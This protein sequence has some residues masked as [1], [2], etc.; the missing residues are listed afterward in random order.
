MELG[1]VLGVELT[2][3][4]S[5]VLPWEDW[6]ISLGWRKVSDD[7]ISAVM[8][9]GWPA[10][11]AAMFFRQRATVSRWARA[12]DLVLLPTANAALGGPF[13]PAEHLLSRPIVVALVRSVSHFGARY[14]VQGCQ[15]DVRYG[16]LVGPEG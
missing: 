4:T 6:L 10:L 9:Y 3:D 1:G 15:D 8:G 11:Q 13:S 7:T 5:T 14:F 12:Q 16:D 2:G